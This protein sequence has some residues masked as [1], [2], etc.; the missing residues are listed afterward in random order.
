MVVRDAVRMR[1]Y[2][3][4][5]V[6]GGIVGKKSTVFQIKT[7]NVE[8][9]FRVLAQECCRYTNSFIDVV[10]NFGI[11]WQIVNEDISEIMFLSYLLFGAVN[12]PPDGDCSF[13][14]AIACSN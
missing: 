2:F 10:F 8:V 5:V 14:A 3:F 11:V 4:V 9:I 7:K 6:G 13:N 1:M 12:E